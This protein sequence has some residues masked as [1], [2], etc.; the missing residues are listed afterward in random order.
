MARVLYSAVVLS[1]HFRKELLDKFQN[2]IPEGWKPFAHHLTINLG[3]LDEDLKVAEGLGVVLKIT[4]IGKSDKAMALKCDTEISKNKVPHITLAVNVNEGGKPVD[5]NKIEVWEP[6]GE[7]I[8][9]MGA[10][11]EVKAQ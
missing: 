2:I 1:E 3:P 4:H 10:I 9:V 6:L 11:T 5:S 7:E 8:F